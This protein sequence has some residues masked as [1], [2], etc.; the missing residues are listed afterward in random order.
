MPMVVRRGVRESWRE[1]V[2]RRAGFDGA[3]AL[4]D[5]DQRIADGDDDAD[6]AYRVLEG[7]DLLWRVDEPGTEAAPASTSA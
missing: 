6:A 3:A 7:R 4:A 2:A 1:A 5:Y